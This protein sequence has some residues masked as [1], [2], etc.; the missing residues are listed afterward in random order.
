MQHAHMI[1]EC[2]CC[3]YFSLITSLIFLHE[4]IRILKTYAL[5]LNLVDWVEGIQIDILPGRGKQCWIERRHVLWRLSPCF[6]EDHSL[7]QLNF[8]SVFASQGPASPQDLGLTDNRLYTLIICLFNERM[9]K[10][11]DTSFTC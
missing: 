10:Y 1:D 11:Q 5:Y 9:N 6:L 8:S 2:C 4:W 3:Y 7:K